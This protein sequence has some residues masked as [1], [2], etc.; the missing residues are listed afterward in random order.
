MTRYPLYSKLGEPRGRYGSV[1]KISPTPGT[2][3]RSVQP[4]AIRYT[5]YAL[6]ANTY[7]RQCQKNEDP[8]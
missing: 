7:V 1:R 3:P 8:C 2:D 6:P 4:L 5:D